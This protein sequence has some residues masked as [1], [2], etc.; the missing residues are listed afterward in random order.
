MNRFD[1]HS[2]YGCMV[3]LRADGRFDL[4]RPLYDNFGR[5]MRSPLDRG[6]VYPNGSNILDR[7][8]QYRDDDRPWETWRK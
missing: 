5:D 3:P 7:Y 2:G 8:N 1:Y 6:T 4:S